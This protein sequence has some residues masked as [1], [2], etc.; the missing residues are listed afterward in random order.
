MNTEAVA[1]HVRTFFTG[2]H[3]HESQWM[4]GPAKD[5]LPQLRILHVAPGPRTKRW[6]FVT[7]GA[8][9][10]NPNNPF[11][12]LI[13][14]DEPRNAYEELLTILAYYAIV[15]NF[16]LGHTIEIGRPLAKGSHCEYLYLSLPYTF[17]PEL[18][19]CRN[20]E[21]EVHILWAFPITTS[22]QRYLLSKGVDALEEQ[23]EKR[24]VKYWSLLRKSVV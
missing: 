1:N 9:S 18:E 10:A 11:E 17:G 22:E 24:G 8:S 6:T 7:A 16:G 5:E 3:V 19:I 12:Y 14:G 20:G 13:I 23:F 21:D 15:H 2:H 4:L